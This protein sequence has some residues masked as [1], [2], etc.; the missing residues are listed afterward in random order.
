M[1]QNFDNDKTPVDRLGSTDATGSITFTNLRL[2]SNTRVRARQVGCSYGGSAV[3]SVRALQTLAVKRI[4][5]RQYVFSGSSIPARPGGLIIS[6]YRIVG[7]PCAAGVDSKSC[8]GERLVGQNRANATTGRYSITLTLPARDA[9]SRG[10]FV[11]KTGRDAQ[12]QPGRTNVRSL[13]IF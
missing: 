4:A 1:K 3:I 2:A 6:L 10:K 12:N 8:P 13:A 7:A 9:N 5:T 11:V